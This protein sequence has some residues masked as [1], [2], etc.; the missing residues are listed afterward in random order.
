MGSK[1]DILEFT[2]PHS[3][4]TDYQFSK[5]IFI[6][7]FLKVYFAQYSLGLKHRIKNILL[8]ILLFKFIKTKKEK[9][10]TTTGHLVSQLWGLRVIGRWREKPHKSNVFLPWDI[11]IVHLTRYNTL[12][13][14][15]IKDYY[16]VPYTERLS[17]GTRF[18]TS[19]FYY[20]GFHSGKFNVR[21]LL[22][23][24]DILHWTQ[25]EM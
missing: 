4:C 5:L 21:V 20:T 3:V 12:K 23:H 11:T 18:S 22:L 17:R 15:R 9:Y 10:L 14:S 24:F 13:V 25:I 6:I 8:Q 1:P 19:D 16:S 7:F 2:V